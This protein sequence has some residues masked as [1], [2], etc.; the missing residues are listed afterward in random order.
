MGIV[1][2]LQ[3]MAILAVSQCR[4]DGHRCFELR[5]RGRAAE[6]ETHQVSFANTL[7]SVVRAV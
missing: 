2:V 3:C 6:R 5:K 7:G 4:R 1:F